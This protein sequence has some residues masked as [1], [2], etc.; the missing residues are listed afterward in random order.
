[1][2]VLQVVQYY[3]QLFLEKFGIRIFSDLEGIDDL[4]HTQNKAFCFVTAIYSTSDET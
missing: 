1:M 2:L 3:D 4:S